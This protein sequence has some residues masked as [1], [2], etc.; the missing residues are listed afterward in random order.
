MKTNY[1]EKMLAMI[2]NAPK[3]AKLLL[4]SCCA[5]CS[6]ACLERL[7]RHFNIT[8][9]YY[10]PNIEREDEYEKRKAE[11]IRFLKETGYATVLDC[12]HGKAAFEEIA[13]GYALG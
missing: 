2:E 6:S 7:F 3:G 1:E 10:N 12:E 5:P 13:K 9:F 8:V 4:H 11:Q